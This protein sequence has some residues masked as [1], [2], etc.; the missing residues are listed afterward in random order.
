MSN[1]S[2]ER[3]KESFGDTLKFDLEGN[4]YFERTHKTEKFDIVL[5]Q[6]QEDKSLR[7]TEK[8][9][10]QTV[11]LTKSINDMYAIFKREA[12]NMTTLKPIQGFFAVKLK[13]A[14]P[15]E[16]PFRFWYLTYP[17]CVEKPHVRILDKSLGTLCGLTYAIE[18]N[19]KTLV[20]KQGQPKRISETKALEMIRSK[21][22]VL[23]S[24]ENLTMQQV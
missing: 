14:I 8:I 20:S 17:K 11:G 10:L 7:R 9:E 3:I 18:F 5:H 24:D 22:A 4:P 21:Q 23:F 6:W 1:Q 16:R 12:I 2:L 13:I 19:D 15:N